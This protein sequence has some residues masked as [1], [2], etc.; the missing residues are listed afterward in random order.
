MHKRQKHRQGSD[1][2]A[3]TGA[4]SARVDAGLATVSG[5]GVSPGPAPLQPPAI[6]EQR[7]ELLDPTRQRFSFPTVSPCPRC[8]G[9]QTRARSTQGRI[10]YRVC[11]AP[12]CQ[13]RFS[14]QGSR[15]EPKKP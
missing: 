15:I 13:Y 10:Q 12:I 5:G 14:I 3:G 2:P 9:T 8:H 6:E 4:E 11:Q 1:A 7:A